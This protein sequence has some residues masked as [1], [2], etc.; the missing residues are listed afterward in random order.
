MCVYLYVCVSAYVCV[1]VR[2]RARVCVFVYARVFV[3]VLII[4]LNNN[5]ESKLTT[6]RKRR[7]QTASSRC[8]VSGSTGAMPDSA[9]ING[10]KKLLPAEHTAVCTETKRID[11][12]P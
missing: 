2:A 5:P 4:D 10:V 3:L 9:E 7:K 11:A 8:S 1:C 12:P 6:Y